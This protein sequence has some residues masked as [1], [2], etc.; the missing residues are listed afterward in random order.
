LRSIL[1]HSGPRLSRVVLVDS[2]SGDGGA[3]RLGS[4]FPSV[5]V[6][7]LE[8]NLGFAHAAN[9]GAASGDED[10]LLLNPDT[11][12][13]AGAVE[14]LGETIDQRPR[15]AAAVP[16][17][18]GA[19]G[20]SQHRWQLRNNP[21]VFRL[22]TGRPGSAAFSTTPTALKPVPQPA[23]AAWLVRR[24]VWNSLGGFNET[25]IPAWWEDVDFCA[26][27]GDLVGRP[28]SPW[29]EGFVVVP[30]ARVSHI[31]GSSVH[32]LS[33]ESFLSSYYL[34]LMRY[35]AAYH[36]GSLALIQAGLQL[37]LRVRMLARPARASGYRAAL[38]S[39]KTAR[40]GGPESPP[41]SAAAG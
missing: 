11:E 15:T 22:A 5:E 14:L 32:N 27:L 40:P 25:Y 24:E 13:S 28:E 39:I 17:L 33:D 31:G 16:L 7:E 4:E 8:R 41:P 3:A 38:R 2:G 36:G 1:N 30:G 12:L 26:R 18:H 20:G 35:A 23:A 19:D 34:N 10:V 37:T 9:T 6:D 21:T 29:R